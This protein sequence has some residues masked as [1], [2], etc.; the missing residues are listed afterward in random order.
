MV[1][2]GGVYLRDGSFEKRERFGR[3]F[4]A[5]ANRALL[6]AAPVDPGT[7]ITLNREVVRIPQKNRRFWFAALLGFIPGRGTVLSGEVTTEVSVLRLGEVTIVMIPGEIAP[8]L[9]LQIKAWGGPF[10]QVWSLAN[11][12][13]G[14]IL[15]PDKFHRDLFRYEAGKSVGPLAGSIIMASVAR[16]LAETG[17][18]RNTFL[19]LPT[20]G[21]DRGEGASRQSGQGGITAGP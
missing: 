20:V 21:E 8:E 14:Y 5:Y 17:P 12:E 3:E 6:Q 19:P 16:L 9:G 10:T 15:H 2:P 18:A 4:A 7:A 13:I 1:R 11:D